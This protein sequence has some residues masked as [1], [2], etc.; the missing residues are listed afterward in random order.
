[1][2][3]LG[4]SVRQVEC[5]PKETTDGCGKSNPKALLEEGR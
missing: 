1:M 3:T 5:V 2:F 4:Q